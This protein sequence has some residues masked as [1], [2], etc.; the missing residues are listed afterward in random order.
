M[1][2]R[3]KGIEIGRDMDMQGNDRDTGIMEEKE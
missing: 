1:R 2:A 3:V